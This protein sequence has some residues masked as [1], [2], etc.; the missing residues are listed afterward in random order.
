MIV[1]SPVILGSNDLVL[2]SMLLGPG[3][4]RKVRVLVTK[5][6]VIILNI[7]PHEE[8]WVQELVSA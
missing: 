6:V 1:S 2:V 4:N 5:I 3:L 8:S 7:L